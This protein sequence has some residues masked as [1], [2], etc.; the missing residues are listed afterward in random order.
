MEKKEK[1]KRGEENSPRATQAHSCLP[2]RRLPQT[3][4]DALSRCIFP[5]PLSL[6]TV[7]PTILRCTSWHVPH[8]QHFRFTS[9]PVF[10][11]HRSPSRSP[12][13]PVRLSH[14]TE[15]HRGTVPFWDSR[16]LPHHAANFKGFNP[17][18]E[19]HACAFLA[20]LYDGDVLLSLESV[21]A[22]YSTRMRGFL[23]TCKAAQLYARHDLTFYENHATWNDI[24]SK[25]VHCLLFLSF[26]LS[27]F[28]L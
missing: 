12:L 22:E 10:L 23:T 2:A 26:F 8:F 25:I 11:P 7:Y 13:L 6:R 21:D 15:T 28:F 27:F 14:P 16:G 20:P 19:A 9:V 17:P 5:P 3:L 1:L 24:V 4:S 18:L